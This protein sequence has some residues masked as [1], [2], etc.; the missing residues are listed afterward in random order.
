ME[1]IDPIFIKI[2]ENLDTIDVQNDLKATPLK[3]Q[4]G[5]ELL[6]GGRAY[7]VNRARDEHGNLDRKAKS[8]FK[9][10]IR[11]YE[12]LVRT[13]VVA[14]FPIDDLYLK[15][16]RNGTV[17][18][19]IKVPA[20]F[21]QSQIY[22]RLFE[23]KQKN[24]FVRLDGSMLNT[25]L[26][27][28]N[29]QF[30]EIEIMVSPCMFATDA[31]L[32][33]TESGR[34]IPLT[35][36]SSAIDESIRDIY[37]HPKFTFYEREI[38]S[39]L[40]GTVNL[41]AYNKKIDKVTTVLPQGA[42][43]SFLLEA[44]AQGFVSPA[45]VLKWFDKVDTRVKYLRLLMKRGIH[46]Y[47]PSL[48]IEQYSFMDSACGVMR[49][50]FK[51]RVANPHLKIDLPELMDLVL[52]TIKEKDSFARQVFE[53]GIHQPPTFRELAD[54]TY[55]VTNLKD[56]ELREGQEEKP[57]QIIA[58]YDASEVIAWNVTRQIRN[59]G[60]LQ[61]R[62]LFDADRP[63]KTVYDHLSYLCVMPIEHISF[64]VSPEFVQQYM[65]GTAELYTI[66]ANALP[67]QITRKIIE[68]TLGFIP[69]DEVEEDLY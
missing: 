19:E 36:R 10:N 5:D 33:L 59:R 18:L 62:G 1:N 15:N 27:D 40:A 43:Y 65:G 2:T 53:S 46:R 52:A 16:V 24:F 57:K 7:T 42:Y 30:D 21:Y 56:M 22:N 20:E 68:T 61:Y 14:H 8:D 3:I 4:V 26:R 6:I 45:L 29:V 34:Q 47:H 67:E 64:D 50:Y 38:T 54:F 9:A 17:L 11:A 25:R 39:R 41:L 31:A 63:N 51:E 66:S 32:A 35:E 12:E 69:E 37:T 23:T 58:V 28:Q 49:T 60:L 13:G 55:A 44:A 48:P